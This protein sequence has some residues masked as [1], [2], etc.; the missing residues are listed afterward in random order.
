MD[1]TTLLTLGAWIA[2]LGVGFTGFSMVRDVVEKQHRA[3]TMSHVVGSGSSHLQRLLLRG[4][5]PFNRIAKSVLRFSGINVL[6]QTWSDVC[7][8]RNLTTSPEALLSVLMMVSLVLFML[9]SIVGSSPLF[10]IMLVICI[11]LGIG[12]YVNRYQDDQKALLREQIPVAIQSMQA[13]FNV[14]YSLPQTFEYLAQETETSNPLKNIFQ[15][16]S[17]AIVAGGSVE[18]ALEIV[19]RMTT[20]DTLVFIASALEIQHKTGASMTRILDSSAQVVKSDL[21]LK[22]ALKTQTAQ[23]KLSAQVITIMPFGLLAIFSLV[24]PGFLDPFFESF[25]GMMLFGAAILMQVAG[26]VLVRRML[27]YEG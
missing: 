4:I 21:A 22:R 6:I 16:A 19:K 7:N 1:I 23:V 13:C 17:A 8:K 14:G 18:E 2:A 15:E 24:S 5:T 20:E 12:I 26:V 3:T 11:L 27:T 9:G 25:A 10:G